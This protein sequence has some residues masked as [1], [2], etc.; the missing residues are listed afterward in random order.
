MPV[1]LSGGG[2]KGRSAGPGREAVAVGEPSHV[3]D[4]GQDPGRN[5]RTN[6]V[7]LHEMRATLGDDYFDLGCQL[8]DLLLDRDQ[9]GQFALPEDLLSD[10]AGVELPPAGA[11]C[12]PQTVID[13][14]AGE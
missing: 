11:P 13:A 9:G 12:R 6:S 10:G 3:T 8:L 5:D 4:I 2:I 1:L 14:A 7:E